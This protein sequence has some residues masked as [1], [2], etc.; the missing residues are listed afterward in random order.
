[1]TPAILAEIKVQENDIDRLA[2][3]NLE[4]FGSCPATSYDFKVWLQ[5]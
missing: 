1:V 4:S 5:R 2:G 3:Q